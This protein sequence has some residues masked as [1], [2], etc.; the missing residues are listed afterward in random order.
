VHAPPRAGAPRAAPRA[1]LLKEM[2]ARR[3]QNFDAG[4][5]DKNAPDAPRLRPLSLAA[6]NSHSRTWQNWQTKGYKKPSKK[7]AST[8]A[9]V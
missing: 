3:L 7:Q 2:A 8:K 9:H 4:F 6:K 5:A 1:I